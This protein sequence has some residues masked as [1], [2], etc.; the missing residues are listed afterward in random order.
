[1]KLFPFKAIYPHEDLIASPDSFFGSV[2]DDYSEY[3]K[4]GFF[5][6][7]DTPA[8]YIMEIK[9]GSRVHSGIVACLDIGDY[10]KGKIV[11]H[12]ETIASSEQAMLKILLQRGA[13]VKPVL[14][15]HPVIK[16][17]SAEITKQKKKRKP[18]IH[19]TTNAGPNEY[20]LY[21]IPQKEGADLANLYKSLIPRV[22]IADG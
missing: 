20:A 11:R 17:I 18:F 8:F 3:F 6:E 4:N 12:E 9:I 21:Q 14:L 15:C 5:D 2:R 10:T 7:S 16:E 19:F 22:Y 13:M 1:M